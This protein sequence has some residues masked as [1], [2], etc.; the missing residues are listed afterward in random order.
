MRE[1]HPRIT[2]VG[3]FL[4]GLTLRV[5]RF[6]VAGESLIGTDFDMGPG[7]KG[8][9]QA[10]GAARLGAESHLVA[11]IGADLFGDMTATLYAEEGVGTTLRRTRE[12]N[13]GAGFIT[14]NADGQN[15]IVLDTGA[16]QLLSP[17]DVDAAEDLIASSG[18]VLSVLEIAPETAGRA[19]QLGR[20][21]GA[22]AGQRAAGV[23]GRADTQR[24]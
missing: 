18:A 23:G 11:V 1:I 5:P 8:S 7:G 13:T 4:V 17:A 21:P 6:P 20:K 3:S 12:R 10:V 22:A 9:N 16:N 15:H 19:M 2:V 24:E 14:L